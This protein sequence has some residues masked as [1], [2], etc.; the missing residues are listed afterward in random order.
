FGDGSSMYAI[1]SL[2]SAAQMNLPMTIVIVNN[3][4]Y[5]ALDQF[6]SHFEIAE[7]VGTQLP[8]IDFVRL[9]ES[10]G[11]KAARVE[12]SADLEDTLRA[13]LVS[14]GPMVVDVGVASEALK[15]HI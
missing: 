12:R 4:G 8:A 1:Q 15:L 3:S 13:A 5:A 10:L 11:C 6:A 14:Q 2:G 9:A 7:P